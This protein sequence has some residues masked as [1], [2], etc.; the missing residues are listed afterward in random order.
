MTTYWKQIKDAELVIFEYS[1]SAWNMVCV[2]QSFPI[3]SIKERAQ[4]V[5]INIGAVII[6]PFVIDKFLDT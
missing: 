1:I 2:N 6:M 3:T 4:K 5:W